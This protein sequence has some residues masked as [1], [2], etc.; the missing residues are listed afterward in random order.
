MKESEHRYSIGG[1]C[2][3]HN[4]SCSIASVPFTGELYAELSM[5]TCAVGDRRC[6][7]QEM[8]PLN[9]LVSGSSL[10]NYNSQSIMNIQM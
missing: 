7:K 1:M 5:T 10:Y 2:L 4:I 9:V 8:V 6:K 3:K